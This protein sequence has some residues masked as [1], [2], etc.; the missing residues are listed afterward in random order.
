LVVIA[1]QIVLAFCV[2]VFQG[3]GA[4]L[5]GTTADP[6]EVGQAV[7]EF[8]MGPTGVSL[9]IVLTEAVFLGVALLSVRRLPG[10]P[11]DNLGLQRPALPWLAYPLFA[12]GAL[13]VALLGDLLATP[14]DTLIPSMMDAQKLRSQVPGA[15]GIP[16]GTLIARAPGFVEELLFRGYVQRRLLR[17]W[18]PRSA[19]LFASLAFAVAHLD[20]VHMVFA[21]PIGLWFGILAWRT[22]SIWPSVA[23]HMFVNALWNIWGICVAKLDVSDATGA[24]VTI[25]AAVCALAGF[26]GSIIVLRR[27]RPY[28]VVLATPVHPSEPTVV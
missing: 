5:R 27:M 7:T 8:L 14:V 25:I 6:S 15:N 12:T 16:F 23:G 3:I 21:L 22:N 24:A 10:G 17:H 19:I 28:S 20:P 4:G 18:R 1:L 2:G 26:V 9:S 13:A 11:R